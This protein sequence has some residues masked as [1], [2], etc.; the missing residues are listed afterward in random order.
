MAALG[1]LIWFVF[2]GGFLMGLGW[3]LAGCILCLTIV[4][5]PFGM[6]CFR[7][8][9]FAFFPFGKELVDMRNLGESRI[10]GTTVANILWF[11]LAGLWLAIGHVLSAIACLASCVLILPLLLGAPAWAVAHLNLAR[12]AL[13][14]LGK[15]IVP[16]GAAYRAALGRAA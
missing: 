6:A 12:V 13:A 14:P 5:I 16:K 4:G 8:A 7:I 10:V 9:S 11:V 3:L 15:R 2:L 1:N